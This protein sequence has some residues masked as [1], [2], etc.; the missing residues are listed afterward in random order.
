MNATTTS[1]N[2]ARPLVVAIMGSYRQNG[3]ISHIVDEVVKAAAD[4]GAETRRFDLEHQHIEFCTNCRC[5][6]QEPGDQRGACIH[7]D[8]MEALLR[9]IEQAD[10]VIIGAP[11]NMGNINALT[12]RFMERCAGF[13]YWPWGS[14]APRFRHQEINKK[15][16]LVSAS[17]APALAG[18][19]L[20]GAHG[21]LK[22]MAKIF[23][24]KPIGTIWVGF[25]SEEEIPIP[26]KHLSQAR[27]LGHAL[28][29]TD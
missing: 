18:R 19:W 22:M 23:G 10:S 4:A 8:D 1:T 16:V 26:D 20:F 27:K 5:C 29:A 25:V 3:V 15:A 9:T 14:P 17:G 13:A 6:M 2:P 24:A 12:R 11:V 28:A 21:A 7:D